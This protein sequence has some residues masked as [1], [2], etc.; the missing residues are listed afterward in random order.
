MTKIGVMS[1]SHGVLFNVVAASEALKECA[2]IVHLGDHER[3]ADEIETGNGVHVI[4]LAGNCD[5]FSQAPAESV[6]EF[7]RVRILAVHGHR[8]GVK[9]GLLHLS[10]KA[11]QIGAALALYGH[12]HIPSI[13][14]ENG[15][16]FVNPGALREGQYA[17]VTIDGDRVSAELRQL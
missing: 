17:V 9:N 1:D 11:E 2:Y 13:L 4:A 10:L 16:T 6:L 5:W 14:T 7:E 12:T 15:I 3:D 8:E